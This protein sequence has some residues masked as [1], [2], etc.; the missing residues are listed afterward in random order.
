MHMRN[1]WA[2]VSWAKVCSQINLQKGWNVS[3]RDPKLR[4]DFMGMVIWQLDL[5]G[6]PNSSVIVGVKLQWKPIKAKLKNTLE[7][8]DE[9]LEDVREEANIAEKVESSAS[10]LVVSNHVSGM[11]WNFR[12]CLDLIIL[13]PNHQGSKSGKCSIGSALLILVLI[14]W[15]PLNF[16]NLK[17]E[18][19]FLIMKGTKSGKTHKKLHCG[20]MPNVTIRLALNES[21]LTWS[22][23]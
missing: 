3:R 18:N 22:K 13:T 4:W 6:L 9:L 11:S 12:C 10:R 1:F 8:L 17:L 7:E 21:W 19:G 16:T 14:T 2:F 5:L 20:S 15:M 23:F